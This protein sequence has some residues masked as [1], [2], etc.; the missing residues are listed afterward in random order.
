MN[1]GWM[2]HAFICIHNDNDIYSRN[3]IHPQATQNEQSGQ[4]F[5]K[6]VRGKHK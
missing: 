3:P 5:G 1:I 6:Y 2:K 4:A